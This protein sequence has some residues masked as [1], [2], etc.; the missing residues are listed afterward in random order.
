MGPASSGCSIQPKETFALK[1]PSP[2]PGDPLLI[3]V[4]GPT[5]SGKSALAVQ[6]ALRL[7]GE[8]VNCDSL[9]LYRELRIGTGKPSAR[10]TES[11]PHHLY[12][13]L[14]PD[15]IYS[16]GRYMV[17]ARRVCHLV[18]DRGKIPFVVGGTGLYLR[19]LLMGVFDG[20]SRCEI[21]RD[22][23]EEMVQRRGQERLHRLLA[24]KDPATARK[25]GVGDRRRL[26]RAL[27]VYYLTGTP[28]SLL[29]GRRKPLAGYRILKIGL[30]L[31]RT[32]LYHR[33]ESRVREM[34]RSGLLD[35]VDRLLRKGYDER[36]KAFEA[37]GY[38]YAVQTLRGELKLEDAI[39]LT[40]RDTRRYAKRQMTWFRREDGMHWIPSPGESESALKQLLELVRCSTNR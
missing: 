12:D 27:E 35:E 36:C 22:R 37:L 30:N 9:Q 31:R 16:A 15:E 7:D 26:I 25:I 14:K 19:A 21:L 39:E 8:I 24:R 6:A 18:R 28:I 1:T 3:A 17:E 11:V 38:R 20:P 4:A 5:A 29:Q 10:E 32:L 33:I 2:S 13:F 40:S 34:F 23:L